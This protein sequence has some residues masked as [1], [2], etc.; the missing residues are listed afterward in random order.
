MSLISDGG[1]VPVSL[2]AIGTKISGNS[3]GTTRDANFLQ[4]T[5]TDSDCEGGRGDD[6]SCSAE[7]WFTPFSAQIG[8][9][10]IFC[11]MDA[12]WNGAAASV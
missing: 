5:L 3:T 2:F 7:M 11:S 8:V 4:Q 9:F 1:A 10:K 12:L 6:G